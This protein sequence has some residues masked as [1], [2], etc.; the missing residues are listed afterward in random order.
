MNDSIE[1]CIPPSLLRGLEELPKNRPIAVLL[2]H[3]VR[4]DLPPGIAGY[5]LPITEAGTQLAQE[6]GGLIGARLRSLHT[7]PLPRCVQ[8]ADALNLGSDASLS[9][10]YDR[11]LG[12]PGVYVIDGQRA[13]LNWDNLGHEGVMQH[14]VTSDEALPGMAQPGPAARFLAHHMLT[15]AGDDPGLH[16]F[17][18]HDSLVTA[19]VARLLEQQLGS[20]AWPWYLEGAFFWRDYDDLH[21]KYR[22]QYLRRKI[23]FSLH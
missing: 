3:S 5:S 12:D 11:L 13:Q 22:D 16:L 23:R 15:M 14:L 7:S 2:R 9:I 8:T 19:T 18:T 10:V 21:I 4:D 6:L 17:V 20:D 1:W